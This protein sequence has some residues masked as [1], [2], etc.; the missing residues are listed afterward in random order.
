MGSAMM[1]LLV[2]TWAG[3]L[4][5]GCEDPLAPEREQALIEARG[6]PPHPSTDPQASPFSATRIDLSWPDNS[7]NESGWEIHRSTTGPSGTFSLLAQTGTNVTSYSDVGLTPTTEYCYRI[8][9]FRVSGKKTTVGT[10]LTTTCAT[11]LGPPAA[12]SDVNA[13]PAPFGVVDILWKFDSF[14]AEGFRL[15]RAAASAGPWVKVESLG[16]W[17]RSYQDSGRPSEQPVCYRVVAFNSYGDAPPSNVDCTTPPAAPATLV[18]KSSDEHTIRLS[19]EDRS[20]A[21]D[22][23]EVQRSLDAS[24][25]STIGTLPANAVAYEDRALAVDTRFWYRVRAAKDGGFSEFS[26]IASAA[27]ASTAPGVPSYFAASPNSSNAVS[28]YWATDSRLAEGYR[29]ERSIDGGASWSTAMTTP[30]Q[31]WFYEEG[32]TSEQQVCYRLFAFNRVGDSPS[33]GACTTPPA[34]PSNLVT[35]SIDDQTVEHQWRDNSAVEDGYELWLTGWDGWDYYYY[36]VSLPANTT[37]YQ[38]SSSEWAYGVVAVKD[39]GYSDWAFPAEVTSAALQSRSKTVS[40]PPASA[41]RTP[42][43]HKPSLPKGAGR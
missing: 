2:L 18:A 16:S 10:F 14:T 3:V 5:A 4:L 39:G 41:Q 30:D 29:L 15:E 24:V 28:V 37:S 1:R 42:P 34:A 11:T 25:W 8:R 17:L 20:A 13:T 21:E 35:I 12:A 38:A 36:P 23:Y 19:W 26:V 40:R 32:L 27:T 33:I 7:T 6:G 31:Y 9:S 22:G 43:E